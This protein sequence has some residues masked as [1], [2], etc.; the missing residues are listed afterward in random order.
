MSNEYTAANIEVLKG[1]DAVKK[2]PGMYIGD[3]DDGSGLHHMIQEVLDN[4][5]DEAL[6]GHCDTV[7]LTLHE[8]GSASVQD[9]GRGMPV[10]MHH[11]EGI[12]G[13]ELIMTRLHAGGKFNSD[14][15]KT[16][17]GM[18]GVGVSVVNAL[19]EWL[20][21]SIERDGSVFTQRYEHGDPTGPLT[22][23]GKSDK[24]GTYVRFKPSNQTFNNILDFDFQ[25]MSERL[26]ELAFLTPTVRIQIKD[27]RSDESANYHYEGG[28]VSFVEHLNQRHNT[29]AAIIPV[30]AEQNNI[31]LNLA[32]QWTYADI[33]ENVNYYTNNIRQKDGGSHQSGLR[34]ALTRAVKQYISSEGLF[35]REKIE[36]IGEDCRDGLTAVLLVKM[37]EPRF[38]SQTKDRLVSSEVTTAVESAVYD[39][40]KTFFLENPAEAKAI[41]EKV[42]NAAKARIAARKVSELT[43]RKSATELDGLPGKLADCQERDP[44]KSELYIVEG[45]SAGGSAKQARDRKTQAVLPLRGKILNVQKATI[46][47]V[48]SNDSIKTLSQALGC[49][50]DRDIDLERLRYHKVIIMTDADVDGAHIRT[51][52]LTAMYKHLRPLIAAGHVYIALPPLY[53]VVKSRNEMFLQN[54]KELDDWTLSIALEQAGLK[55]GGSEEVIRGAPLANLVSQYQ[56]MQRLLVRL[57]NQYPLV[58]LEEMLHVARPESL[59]DTAVLQEY[60]ERLQRVLDDSGKIDTE[61]SYEAVPRPSA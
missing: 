45:D 13:A 26:R 6:A 2:R 44:A 60:C 55:A 56:D 24:H 7:S 54:D 28:L 14:S 12:T 50:F 8:D 3:T 5:I 19:S 53:K 16:S 46:E 35:K 52:I 10:D 43:K 23:T 38:S 32:L 34:T 42:L 29:V 20:E 57:S 40:L 41:A 37:V 18:H 48:L 30:Y 47:K 51:L 39:Q 61:V 49:G 4:S 36:I 1:L 15:Y 27:E 11:E 21:L 58:L 59:T 17:G 25:K 31:E 22:E 9:N 33:R